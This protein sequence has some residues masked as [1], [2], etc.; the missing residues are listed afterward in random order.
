MTQTYQYVWHS[1]LLPQ[2]VVDRHVD[3]SKT[4]LLEVHTLLLLYLNEISQEILGMGLFVVFY[5]YTH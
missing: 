4:F 5:F 3:H 2:W 1:T